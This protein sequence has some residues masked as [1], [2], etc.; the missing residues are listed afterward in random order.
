[1]NNG[2][3][4]RTV[5]ARYRW[6]ISNHEEIDLTKQVHSHACYRR[7]RCF[8]WEW[9]RERVEQQYERSWLTIAGRAP[10]RV[11][12]VR[13]RIERK[14]NQW[15]EQDEARWRLGQER[16][17]RNEAAKIVALRRKLV[18]EGK[19]P[20]LDSDAILDGSPTWPQSNGGTPC[21]GTSASASPN[22]GLPSRKTR[23]RRSQRWSEGDPCGAYRALRR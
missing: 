11:Q 17:R 14:R 19:P 22:V 2:N 4:P 21:R 20:I 16:R 1:M 7:Y 3:S 5:I 12:I 10:P 9:D 15:R 13:D 6:H 8:K 18:S 23:F